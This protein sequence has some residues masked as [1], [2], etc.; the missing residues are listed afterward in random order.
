MHHCDSPT[1][2]PLMIEGEMS[3]SLSVRIAIDADTGVLVPFAL[4]LLLKELNVFVLRNISRECF[5]VNLRFLVPR[6][7]QGNDG[8]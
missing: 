6:V 2:K 3:I 5:R 1:I 7:S 4:P 8:E